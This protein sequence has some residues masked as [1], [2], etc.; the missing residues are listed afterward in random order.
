MIIKE[1]EKRG[2]L[3][4]VA[5]VEAAGEAGTVGF[6]GRL[7][8]VGGEIGDATGNRKPPAIVMEQTVLLSKGDKLVLL[9]GS[10]DRLQD[11]PALVAM[12]KPALTSGTLAIIY[13]VNLTA[14]AQVELEGI[15]FVL[16]PMREGVVWNELMDAGHLDKGDL[17][18]LASGAKVMAV[19]AALMSDFKAKGEAMSL[20][21]AL[22]LTADIKRVER[23]AL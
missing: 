15:N 9:A 7:A 11:L 20:E 3:L 19:Y 18:K 12:Y 14:M 8:L 21:G 22:S 17:K 4:N 10:L 13:V 6:R 23:G 2:L 16:I 1:F 5:F